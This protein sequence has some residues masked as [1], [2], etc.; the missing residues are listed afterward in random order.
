MRK[1]FFPSWTSSRGHTYLLT[2]CRSELAPPMPQQWRVGSCQCKT[3]SAP[4]VISSVP[5][6]QCC[7]SSALWAFCSTSSPTYSKILG[8]YTRRR[9]LTWGFPPLINLAPHVITEK[10]HRENFLPFPNVGKVWRS[11]GGWE[12][13]G[14]EKKGEQGRG[15]S[16]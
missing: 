14:A 6:A 8:M 11:G 5:G 15:E 4:G 9:V 7:E 10:T 12:G 13:R 16:C 2:G 3:F 1:A